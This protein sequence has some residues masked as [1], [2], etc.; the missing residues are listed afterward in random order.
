MG[1]LKVIFLQSLSVRPISFSLL[2]ILFSFICPSCNQQ[3]DGDK[4]KKALPQNL[5]DVDFDRSMGGKNYP[6]YRALI[7]QDRAD[8][9]L[10]KRVYIQNKP[11][12]ISAVRAGK[13]PRSIH[14]IW[15]GAKP[16]PPHLEELSKSFRKIHPDWEYHIWTDEK[17]ATFDFEL[18][19]LFQTYGD[20][21]ESI[22]KKTNILRAEILDCFGGLVVDLDFEAIQ[23]LDSLHAKY[24][25]Y[26]AL[27][28]PQ[29]ECETL[30]SSKII[31]AR[32]GHPI[33]KEWKKELALS[34]CE[35]F[36]SAVTKKIGSSGNVDV[37]FPASYF[38]PIS[39]TELVSWVK[40]K[41]GRIRSYI[42]S[43]LELLHIKTKVPFSDVKS[44]TLAICYWGGNVLKTKE[45]C[46]YE[47]YQD[48]QYQQKALSKELEVLK[49]EI[50][51]LKT[52]NELAFE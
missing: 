8:L 6:E 40:H 34:H 31:A 1:Q 12:R 4:N 29:K 11:S 36:Q 16:V 39:S 25:F 52:G 30:V 15:L 51:K 27:A 37:V 14:Q 43:F 22:Q 17:I 19:H 44:E 38:Y 33:I 20:E 28:L 41:S 10:F 49:Q 48:L 35:A 13:I 2:L 26:T 9:Q 50:R 42:Q 7:V 21:A 45:Q 46:Y 23:P 5:L 18:K 47:L 32:S 3:Q 24:D